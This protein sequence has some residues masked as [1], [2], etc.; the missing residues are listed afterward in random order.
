MPP[1]LC[2]VLLGEQCG[3]GA[4][5]LKSPVSSLQNKLLISHARQPQSNSFVHQSYS[6][7]QMQLHRATLF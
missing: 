1:A 7:N 2:S 6:L 5:I 3:E 4:F